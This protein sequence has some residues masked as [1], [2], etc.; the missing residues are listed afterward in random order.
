MFTWVFVI[1]EEGLCQLAAEVN[2]R[3]QV[4]KAQSVCNLHTNCV[5]RV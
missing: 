5:E 1:A 3:E 4:A 2:K